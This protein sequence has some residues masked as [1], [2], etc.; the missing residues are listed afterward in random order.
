MQ[1]KKGTSARPQIIS[2]PFIYAC[3]CLQKHYPADL[4]TASVVICF[5]NEEFNALFRTMS[6]VINLTP[7]H[8]LE[9]IILVDDMSDFGKTEH[10]PPVSS[11]PKAVWSPAELATCFTFGGCWGRHCWDTGGDVSA[12]PCP[13]VLGS[14]VLSASTRW[15]KV[16]ART[17]S[18]EITDDVQ[19]EATSKLRSELSRWRGGKVF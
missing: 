13:V 17:W 6:S 8:I 10:H 3:R 19:E 2:F 7:H 12:G 14:Q 16:G 5:H 9:E 18:S 11:A 15:L 4:P 1:I